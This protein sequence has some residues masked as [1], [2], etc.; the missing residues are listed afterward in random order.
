MGQNLY[1]IYVSIQIHTHTDRRRSGPSENFDFGACGWRS[2]ENMD[3]SSQHQ[4]RARSDLLATQK[5]HIL[6]NNYV[7]YVRVCV[8]VC[9]MFYEQAHRAADA[10]VFIYQTPGLG[11]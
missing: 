4:R 6:H 10:V 5:R 9:L 1:R 11:F 2:C 3:L 7:V 8:C